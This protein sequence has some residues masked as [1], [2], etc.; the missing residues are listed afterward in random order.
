MNI[1][2]RLYINE[3]I[4]QLEQIQIFQTDTFYKEA[5]ENIVNCNQKKP[6][7]IAVVGE[8][9]TGK[10]TFINAILGIDLLCHATEEVTATITNIHNVSQNDERYRTCDVTFMNGDTVHI[11]NDKQLIQYTTTKSKENDVVH[12][13]KC[14]DYY[15]NYMS[16]DTD[17]VIV[18][19]PGLNGMA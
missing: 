6:F 11:K 16:D 8:F 12:E 1:M 15:A 9:S 17:I 10:S 18:D 5:L 13:I 2:D 4:K 14:V 19:T 3:K 7:K